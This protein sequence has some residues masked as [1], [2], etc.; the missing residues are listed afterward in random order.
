MIKLL[1]TPGEVVDL[2]F[3][4]ADQ[5]TPTSIKETKIDAVQQKYLR[6]ALGPLFNALSDGEYPEL[7][8]EYIKPALAYFVRYAVVP[9]LSLKLNDIGAQV[10]NQ[11]HANAATDKQRAEMRQQAKDD[12]NALLDK[13]QRYIECNRDK[14]PEYDPD[15]NIR[16]SVLLNGG[17]ILN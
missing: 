9:D 14:F 15:M 2:A 13:A 10:Y 7:L 8:C 17:I 4:P 5:I 1:I 12:A 6:S 16:K 11:M 3:S